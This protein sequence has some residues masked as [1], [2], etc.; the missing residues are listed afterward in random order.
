MLLLPVCLLYSLCDEKK[1]QKFLCISKH[2][3]SNKTKDD[4]ILHCY[5]EAN[6]YRMEKNNENNAIEKIHQTNKQTKQQSQF[7]LNY[8]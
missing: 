3:K 4:S 1:L 8:V 2:C 6:K 7:K 5:S